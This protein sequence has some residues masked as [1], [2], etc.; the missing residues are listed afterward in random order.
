MDRYHSKE[1]AFFNILSTALNLSLNE[2]TSNFEVEIQDLSDKIKM[3][4]EEIMDNIYQL[5]NHEILKVKEKDKKSFILDLSGYGT[6]LAEVF[7]TEEIDEMLKE[8]DFFITKYS[9]LLV[10]TEKLIP[11][12]EET[13]IKLK[14][15]ANSDLNDMI[16]DGIADVF[17]EEIIIIL[18]K[19]IYN[20]C[21]YADEKDL[22]IIEVIL[23]CFYNFGKHENPFLVT[24]FLASIFNNI[25]TLLN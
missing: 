20:M 9:N 11:Y 2:H 21:E 12:I 7:T 4:P 25:E 15:D 18:E 22:E 17:T 16:H 19:K 6:K 1:I 8:F 23:F 14:K 5:E 24:L 13:K 3:S 10:K